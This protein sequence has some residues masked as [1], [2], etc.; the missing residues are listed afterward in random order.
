MNGFSFSFP[1]TELTWRVSED[2][3]MIINYISTLTD[4]LV[5]Q[6]TKYLVCMIYEQHPSFCIR[7]VTMMNLIN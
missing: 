6:P 1:I 2:I 3:I 5:N 7:A 4:T